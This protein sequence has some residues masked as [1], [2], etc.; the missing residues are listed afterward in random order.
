MPL[1]PLLSVERSVFWK[2][3]PCRDSEYWSD[4]EEGR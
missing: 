3:C 1:G 2:Y 4:E